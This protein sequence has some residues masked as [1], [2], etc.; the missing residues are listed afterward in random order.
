M[1]IVITQDGPTPII[2]AVQIGNVTVSGALETPTVQTVRVP[3]D[4]V[5]AVANR[6]GGPP[7]PPGPPGEAGV[8]GS[9]GLAGASA[10]AIA[11]SGGFVGT[12]AEWLDSL[13]G[14]PGT[15]DLPEWD[16][17]TRYVNLLVTVPSNYDVLGTPSLVPEGFV[18]YYHPTGN[19]PAWTSGS[20]SGL[21]AGHSVGGNPAAPTFLGT[22]EGGSFFYNHI[23]VDAA[24]LNNPIVTNDDVL[25]YIPSAGGSP[26]APVVV[27]LGTADAT[28][29][30][31]SG[32]T[33][34]LA[35]LEPAT[36]QQALDALDAVVGAPGADGLSAYEVAVANGFVGDES[37]WL[38]S[39][40]GAQGDAGAPGA[41]ALWNFLG[42]YDLGSAYAVGDVVTYDGETWYRIDAHGGNTGDTPVEG[43]FWTKLSAKG[44]DGSNGL[45]GSNGDAATITVGS[46]TTAVSGSASVTNS[47]TSSAAVLDFVI[48]QG[49]Q[50]IPGTTAAVSGNLTGIDSISTLDYVQFDTSPTG[51]AATARLIW[52]STDGTLDLGMESGTA[53]MTTTLGQQVV[54]MVTNVSGTT[55]ATAN[56]VYI[57]GSSGNR[58]AVGLADADA[59]ATASKTLGL[60]AESIA[61]NQAGYI[62]TEGLLHTIN[63]NHLTEG[64]L[65]WLSAGTAGELTSTRPA[66]PNHGVLIGLCVRKHAVNGSIFVKVANGYELD[67][68]H[69]VSIT[70]TPTNGSVLGYST[71][72]SLW[73]PV[74]SVTPSAH[75]ASH[76]STG[77]D[78]ITV[79]Q[80]QVT[81]LTTDLAAKVPT[82]RTVNGKALSS[83]VTLTASDVSAVASTRIV[84]AGTG[85]SGGGD[86]SANRTLS[87]TYGT[88]AN[89][90]AQGNDSRLSDARTPTSHA[91]SHASTGSDSLSLAAS[92]ITSGTLAASRIASGGTASTSV[93]LR[94]DQT[95]QGVGLYDALFGSVGRGI[96]ST[97]AVYVGASTY[98]LTANRLYV[99][100][101]FV[102]Q[103]ITI[104]QAQCEVSTLAASGNLVMGIYSAALSNNRVEP[105]SL[106]SSFGAVSVA[107][108]G[109]K[110][111]SSLSVAV[112][113]GLYC[114][115]WL[116]DSA[117]TMRTA[118]A[119]PLGGMAGISTSGSSNLYTGM[120][121]SYVS[122]TYTSPLP[123]TAPSGPVSHDTSGA[124]GQPIT[125]SA[126]WV[127]WTLA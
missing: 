17:S 59:E 48:P 125:M 105:T 106:L 40:V 111:L 35:G 122:Q 46:T 69:N 41:D 39:L 103:P 29:V 108:T 57:S 112:N 50:G 86:L 84:S 18:A 117:P 101:I 44:S 100:P 47:G 85:L 75:A 88:T 20:V 107:T 15:S 96:P 62:V 49:P 82:T 104:T 99:H 55:I 54:Q 11:V 12:E 110:T 66:A 74:T 34:N 115:A 42:A 22:P 10:Y 118:T 51:A 26:N 60:A 67:E 28:T 126:V 95:W 53:A 64:A 123:G 9:Q 116:A 3:G 24:N 81:N 79:A 78:A 77:S 2:T 102:P 83:D 127:D 30:N 119:Y 58:I 113:P 63:T 23:Q 61:D 120:R 31:I 93:F 4:I 25:F 92:Q 14:P 33:G 37:A 89:T 52:N 36:V 91:A 38:A 7:G 90:A 13:Q 109:A 71:A 16:R 80:S 87:V 76:A 124:S 70:S 6:A 68:L 32:F 45:P 43:L 73:S 65:V 27:P 114:I 94:G 19:P 72:T 56:A 97:L 121:A 5:L 98:A 1:A 8:Q 21:Y